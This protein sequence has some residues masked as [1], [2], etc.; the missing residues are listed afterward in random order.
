MPSHCPTDVMQ[1][2]NFF[3]TTAPPVLRL[4]GFQRSTRPCR[5]CQRSCSSWPVRRAPSRRKSILPLMSCRRPST[6]ERASYS[7]SWRSTTA[8]NRRWRLKQN[9]LSQTQIQFQCCGCYLSRS[10]LAVVIWYYIKQFALSV[11]VSGRGTLIKGAEKEM[12]EQEITLKS[13]QHWPC[14]NLLWKHIYPPQAVCQGLSWSH[15]R[16]T[17]RGAGAPPHHPGNQSTSLV[18]CLLPPPNPH[19]PGSSITWVT[20]DLQ[21]TGWCA[22]KILE[23]WG[24]SDMWLPVVL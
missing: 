14:F 1:R 7:W 12:I 11:S 9:A 10:S 4:L 16:V 3:F 23:P 5:H 8:S 19:P 21:L 13:T 6:S 22:V 20:N 2:N 18:K 15:R 17:G 24:K